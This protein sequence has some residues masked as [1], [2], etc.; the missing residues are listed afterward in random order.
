[1]QSMRGNAATW[2]EARG[3]I[4]ELESEKALYAVRNYILEHGDRL[5]QHLQRSKE[6]ESF[7]DGPG[8]HLHAPDTLSG[9]K[10]VTRIG[11]MERVEWFFFDRIF[12]EVVCKDLDYRQVARTLFDA[13]LLRKETNK[14]TTKIRVANGRPAGFLISNAIL[15][16]DE[17]INSEGEASSVP[18]KVEVLRPK[19]VR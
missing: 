12:K 10:L 16:E 14:W 1:M 9:Y 18:D 5:F 3:G 17:E 7:S 6:T 8:Y 13:K 4:K 15:S 11:E 2:I 19:Y